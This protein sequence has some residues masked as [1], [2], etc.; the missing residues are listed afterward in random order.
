[1]K[2]V[3]P[4][5]AANSEFRVRFRREVAVARTVSGLFTAVVVDA[6]VDAPAPWL[7]TAYVAGPS[8]AQ[9]V[10]AHGRLPADS[11]LALAAGLAESLAAIHGAGLVHRDLKPSNVLLAEDGPRVIDFGISRAVEATS[12]TS[13]G[14]VV[15]SPGFMS[16][17]TGP[18]RRCRAAER[19]VQPGR[20]SCLRRHRRGAVRQRIY[21]CP[22]LPRGPRRAGP[23]S[24]ADSGPAVDRALH[25]QRSRR[26]ACGRR[27][28]RADR[29]CP[30]GDRLAT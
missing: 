10:E 16:P 3:R 26:A 29:P 8:L 2:V 23:E 21:P 15:G 7:A 19:H 27:L 13:T 4:E 14:L 18:R 28:S 20:G 11:V 25:G 5:L 9:A 1:V 22:D 17:R 24:G 12:L 6:D 30:A